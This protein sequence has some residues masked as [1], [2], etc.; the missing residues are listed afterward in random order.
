MKP[1]LPFRFVCHGRPTLKIAIRFGWLPGAR[2]TNLRDIRGFDRIGLIDV[3]WRKYDFKKHLEAVKTTL[4]VVTIARD[5]ERIE[6]LNRTL[7]QASEL[8]LWSKYVVV[9]PKDIRFALE[10]NR[11]P[12]TF[13][14]GY[15][16]PTRYGG[17]SIPVS[18]FLGRAIHLLGGRPDVQHQLS[19]VLK[20]F[21]FDGNRFTVD[22]AYGD[23][24]D[25]RRF[26]P[27]RRGGYYECI[28]SSLRGINRLWSDNRRRST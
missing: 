13:I 18:S 1:S 25:G 22:A 15:S 20:V 19:R 12:G 7:D 16:V 24:F 8:A 5:L 10:M 23:Y 26:I 21:S 27:H 2:Y 4:P 9:V 3:D 11:I 17:T 28:R 6:E 14:I